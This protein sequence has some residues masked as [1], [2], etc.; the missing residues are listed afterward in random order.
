MELDISHENSLVDVAPVLHLHELGPHTEVVVRIDVTDAAGA[1]WRSANLYRAD[2]RG[3]V[4]TD[5]DA[6]LSGTYEGVDATGPWWSMEC[7][8]AP[9]R[10]ATAFTAPDS[11]LT[12]SV[13]CVAQNATARL[14]RDVVRRWR[15][16][17]VSKAE[18]QLDGMRLL[19][20]ALPSDT[21][22]GRPVVVV[23]PGTTGSEAVSPAAALLASRTGFD[24]VVLDYQAAS[25][26]PALREVPLE[27]LASGIDAAARGLPSAVVAYSVGTGGALAALALTATPVR[28]AVAIAP[29]HVIWQ[30]LANSGRPP[31]TSAWSYQSTPMAYAPIRGEL[32]LPQLAY[33]ALANRF[34][35]R[36]VRSTA[37]RLKPA[38]VAG[39]RRVP[40]DAVIPVERIAAPLMAIAGT[41]DAMWPSEHMARA[42]I[43]RR[44]SAAVPEAD[45]LMICPKAGHFLRPPYIPTTVDRNADL[46][47]GGVPAATAKAQEE[48]WGALCAFLQRHLH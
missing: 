8:P 13:E 43:D 35:S 7:R 32:L 26:P 33:H 25:D 5:R 4:R 1:T 16:D 28:A 18:E 24:T 39:L 27:R 48:S 46:V 44:R 20:F 41:D 42:L 12:W 22:A 14:R 45:V 23:V 6:P 29:T 31:Q 38:Y 17:P 9:G 36:A 40:P 15:A 3:T 10:P 2:S 47:A 19:R 21:S 11:A 37:L 30:A 34:R